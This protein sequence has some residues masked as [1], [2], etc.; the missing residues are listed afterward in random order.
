MA[1]ISISSLNKYYGDKH[2]L[3]NISF[4]ILNGEKVAIVGANG[5][6][7]TTLFNILSK[8][9]DYDSGQVF[10]ASK[11]IGVI[12]QIPKFNPEWTVLD[13]LNSAF[14]YQKKLIKNLEEISTQLEKN[15]NDKSLIKKYGD[16]SHKL[17]NIDGYSFE[18]KIDI[19]CNGLQIDDDMRNKEFNIL[20][21]GEKTRVNLAR[22]I[23]GESDILL[24]DEPTNHLDMSSVIWLGNYMK[25]YK[26][27]AVIISHDRYFIDEVCSRII[28]IEDGICDFYSGAYTYYIQEKNTRN[29]NKLREIEKAETEKNRLEEMSRTMHQWG[30][31]K[32]HK[33]AF[34]I[35]KKIDK[36]HIDD[37]PKTAKKMNIHFNETEYHTEEILKVKNVS[38]SFG[39]KKILENIDFIVRNSERV[40]VIGDNGTGKSTL[41]KLIL[42]ELSPDTGSLT[43][44]SGVKPAYLPQMV[45]FENIERNL[46]DTLIYSKNL[47]PQTARNRLGA[48]HF[49]GDTQHKTVKVL[50]GGE[51]SR[52][53]L[54]E[55][56]YDDI[57]LLIL[58]EP[59]NHLDILSREWIEEAV[60]NFNGTLI[61]V[62]HDR[63][64]INRF[65]TRI[66]QL[67]GDGF[68]DFKG[69]YKQFCELEEKNKD[70]DRTK[71]DIQYKHIEKPAKKA[72]KTKNTLKKI[73]AL[74]REIANLENSIIILDETML[75][76]SSDADKLLE[77]MADKSIAQELLNNKIDEWELLSLE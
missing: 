51:K 12:D 24:L 72:T 3:K 33:R 18:F 73:N 37:K 25:S 32:M 28:E 13:V 34:S 58:D 41:L 14:E 76:H 2:I 5:A 69:T 10:L 7:K 68:I 6:G 31:A 9:L 1:D 59:T 19:V 45:S 21:G 74:E 60:E 77:I 36:I 64:F 42:K 62:S 47:T 65:A 46:I 57:N 40:A 11:N 15:S 43:Q 8:G 49:S 38:K 53:K 35:D 4:D 63:Y 20:S 55:M 39:D 67:K 44:A 22:I 23:L 54:C 48:F 52:L 66:I 56:L 61:F 70:V 16:I 75:T 29:E 50:S 71:Q 30:T 26:G 17:E 27:T